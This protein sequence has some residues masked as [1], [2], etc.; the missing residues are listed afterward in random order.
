MKPARCRTAKGS[1]VQSLIS[2]ASPV[3]AVMPAKTGG[4]AEQGALEP[5]S[6]SAEISFAAIF[7]QGVAPITA[8]AVPGKPVLPGGKILPDSG[9]S[10]DAA[11]QILSEGPTEPTM[12]PPATQLVA[13]QIVAEPA[14]LAAMAVPPQQS[15]REPDGE[16]APTTQRA[17][18][19]ALTLIPTKPGLAE[20]AVLPVSM[21]DLVQKPELPVI[22]APVPPAANSEERAAR[23]AQLVPAPEEQ[24]LPARE[25]A[26]RR[27]AP[28]GRADMLPVPQAAPMPG[29]AMGA[30]LQVEGA[31]P[32]IQISFAGPGQTAAP[33][34]LGPDLSAQM[35]RDFG[36][37]IDRLASSR[38][39]AAPASGATLRIALSHAEFGSV[40]M[41]FDQS[42]GNLAI[43]VSSADPTFAPAV[44]A[45]LASDL[46][47]NDQTKDQPRDQP[48][49]HSQ[50]GSGP[51]A[52]NASGQSPQGQ[53]QSRSNPEARGTHHSAARSAPGEAARADQS[54][55]NEH[56]ARP[57]NGRGL[58]I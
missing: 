15:S 17:Q 35:P 44:R 48:R 53:S 54:S 18:Q 25:N 34:Q 57:A 40:A 58:Y 1:N 6:G 11:L 26:Q 52:E 2:I 8:P 49:E 27:V 45:A 23:A 42:G 24:R 50:R 28:I 47:H 33:N 21:P 16:A 9:N 14:V 31:A 55:A 4:F 12:L 56:G 3:G 37:L 46:A 32:A 19:A 51:G 39:A 36:A 10:A 29:I 43:G 7:Q 13:G 38:E 5:V 22:K 41:R 30:F 20:V